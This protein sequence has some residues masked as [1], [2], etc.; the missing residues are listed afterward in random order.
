MIAIPMALPDSSKGIAELFD[1]AV[2]AIAMAWGHIIVTTP[3]SRLESALALLR[4]TGIVVVDTE[5]GAHEASPTKSRSQ[6]RPDQT[7]TD[8]RVSL[9]PLPTQTAAAPNYT[10][11]RLARMSPTNVK[12]E[13]GVG[14]R[15]ASQL[16]AAATAIRAKPAATAMARTAA[17]QAAGSNGAARS[18]APN[19]PAPGQA[20]VPPDAASIDNAAGDPE[21]KSS[22]PQA[23]KL[24]NLA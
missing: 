19:M 18:P 11:A 20:S 10:R 4:A 8:H 22:N 23:G 15:H 14:A 16:N 24:S 17:V 21:P 2:R 13:F 5:E 7:Q 1:A 6:G 3:P 12:I 9:P